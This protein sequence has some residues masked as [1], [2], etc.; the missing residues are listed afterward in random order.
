MIA[1]CSFPARRSQAGVN[2][3]KGKL[4][5]VENDN[6]ADWRE[7]WALFPGDVAYV[8]HAG[9]FPRVRFLLIFGSRR[10]PKALPAAS[11]RRE[12]HRHGRCR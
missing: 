5:R 1:Q 10:E 12:F 8:W 2:A 11:I 3:N 9:R 7:A 4:G 6:R